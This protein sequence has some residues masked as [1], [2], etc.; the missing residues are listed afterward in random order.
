MGLGL[1]AGGP[2]SAGLPGFEASG[3]AASPG[4]LDG[5]AGG[6]AGADWACCCCLSHSSEPF[7]AFIPFIPMSRPLLPSSCL[8]SPRRSSLSPFD[9]RSPVTPARM[10]GR[11]RHVAAGQPRASRRDPGAGAAVKAAWSG[12]GEC[13]ATRACEPPTSQT[14]ASTT[15]PSTAPG[16]AVP[17]VHGAMAVDQR[18][19]PCSRQDR[20]GEPPRD[21]RST[22]CRSLPPRPRESP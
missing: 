17:R 9:A 2:V 5:A 15:A 14:H 19:I 16:A 10:R 1:A 18:V 3:G 7:G 13:S 22:R 8:N 11:K 12:V 20:R 4:V 21:C 6:D